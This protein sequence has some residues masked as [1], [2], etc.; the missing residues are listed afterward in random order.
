MLY[1]NSEQSMDPLERHHTRVMC[2]TLEFGIMIEVTVKE[3]GS[4]WYIWVTGY[5]WATLYLLFSVNNSSRH[6]ELCN[7]FLHICVL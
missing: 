6:E 5:C 4:I 7:R 1:G 3:F 2:S